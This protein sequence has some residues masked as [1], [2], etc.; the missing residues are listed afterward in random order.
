MQKSQEGKVKCLGWC[1]KIFLSKDRIL[2]RFCP[3]CTAKK[4]NAQD[5]NSLKIYGSG[6][7]EKNL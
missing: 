4:N 1:G 6:G 5:K 2:I 7:Y 3:A